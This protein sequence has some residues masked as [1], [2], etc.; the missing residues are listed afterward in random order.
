[1]TTTPSTWTT[2]SELIIPGPLTTE[3][4]AQ[5]RDYAVR[6]FQAVDGTGLARVDFL[7]DDATGVTLFERTQHD[8]RLH[9]Y[10]HVS[11][12]LGSER[13]QLRGIGEPARGLGH[14]TIRRQATE[15]HNPISATTLLAG[16]NTV[17]SRL[18]CS[19]IV[20]CSTRT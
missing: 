17:I 14:G 7:L 13:R 11:E 19:P 6:A 18:S 5:V 16:A 2:R 8:A 1:M 15:S 20:S 9:P 10:Q 3:Q 12:T 4:T